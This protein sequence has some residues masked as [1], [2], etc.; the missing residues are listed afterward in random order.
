[1]ANTISD[2]LC[3]LVNTT[4]T[5]F[6]T[7]QNA[8]EQDDAAITTAKTAYETASKNYTNATR[9]KMESILHPRQSDATVAAVGGSRK[10]NAF[11]RSDF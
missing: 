2:R 6:V 9:T 8:P 7:V 4:N 5:A 10:Y 3:T 11:Q 1:M